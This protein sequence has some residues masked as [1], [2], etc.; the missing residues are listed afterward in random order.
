MPIIMLPISKFY[1]K[2]E[3]GWKAIVGAIIAVAGAAI[4]FLR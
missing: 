4:L 3:L 2:E 1:F